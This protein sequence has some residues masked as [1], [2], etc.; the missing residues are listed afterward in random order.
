MSFVIYTYFGRVLK[1][2]PIREDELHHRALEESRKF[3]VEQQT[4]GVV[5]WSRLRR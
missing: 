4:M 3:L 5:C 2:F 1:S